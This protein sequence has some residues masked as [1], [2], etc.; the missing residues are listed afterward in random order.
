MEKN[1]IK[2]MLYLNK[3][4]AKLIYKDE[5]LYKYESNVNDIEILFNV[6]IADMGT[7]PNIFKDEMEAKFLIR[8]IV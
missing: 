1:E 8:W 2:K 7:N 4:K 5:N 3:P 6:P